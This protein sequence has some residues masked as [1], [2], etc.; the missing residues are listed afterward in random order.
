[1]GICFGEDKLGLIYM[2]HQWTKE[3]LY[4]GEIC[5][6]AV[7]QKP[8]LTYNYYG[9]PFLFYA[10]GYHE[11]GCHKKRCHAF[12][13]FLTSKSNMLLIIARLRSQNIALTCWKL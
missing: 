9:K 4:I 8:T 11:C 7:W 1:M 12:P 13:V 5:A 3:T 6:M 10:L 2:P